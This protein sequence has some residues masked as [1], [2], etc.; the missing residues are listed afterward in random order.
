VRCSLP[1]ATTAALVPA[2]SSLL[3]W[4]GA[5]L[6]CRHLYTRFKKASTQTLVEY[7]HR[8]SL[9]GLALQDAKD[10][11]VVRDSCSL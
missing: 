2:Q 10:I 7:M 5:L 11:D 6:P 3:W 1:T 9:K 8:E 4:A